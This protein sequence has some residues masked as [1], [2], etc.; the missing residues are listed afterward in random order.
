MKCSLHTY[1]SPLATSAEVLRAIWTQFERVTT[2][3]S[4][5]TSKKVPNRPFLPNYY[6]QKKAYTYFER[7]IH[8]IAGTCESQGFTGG[9]MYLW[10]AHPANKKCKKSKTHVS[11][12]ARVKIGPKSV[13]VE[14]KR[15]KIVFRSAVEMANMV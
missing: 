9:E 1:L 14:K 3:I 12:G 5:F 10:S 13:Q 2:P 11:R 8:P 15:L 6:T 7:K 4:R